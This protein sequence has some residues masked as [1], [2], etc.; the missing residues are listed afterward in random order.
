MTRHPFGDAIAVLVST[1]VFCGPAIAEVWGVKTNAGSPSSSPPASLF[2]FSEDGSVFQ[3]V[4]AV[5]L[6]GLE[7]DVDGL[8]IYGGALY[9]FQVDP[10]GGGSRLIRIDTSD[11]NAVVVGLTLEGRDIRGA[12]FDTD[13]GLHG[14]DAASGELLEIDAASGV[15]VDAVA[16][17]LDGQPI[18]IGTVTDIS[19]KPDQGLLLSAHPEWGRVIYRVDANTGV[20][21]YEYEDANPGDDGQ[22]L[23]YA[24]LAFSDLSINLQ[25][26]FV[27]D[28]DMGEDIYSYDTA[29]AWTRTLLFGNIISWYNAGRGDLAAEPPHDP[30]AIVDPGATLGGGMLALQPSPSNTGAMVRFSLSALAAGHPVRLII[31]DSAGRVVRDLS[32]GRL[33]AGPHQMC[34][35]GR[36]QAGN[37]VVSGLYHVRLESK[38]GSSFGRLVVV[39]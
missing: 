33:T 19:Q 13:G 24:G 26:L 4:G 5:T 6:D 18:D 12:C 9:G 7:I 21:T 29:A 17:T 37:A 11:A 36:D 1:A 15:V 25:T 34:W 10:P 30:T 22:W 14:L 31:V 38:D 20:L 16:L 32:D 2:H 39:K 3:E 28:I 8:A 35:D 27:Y 23:E